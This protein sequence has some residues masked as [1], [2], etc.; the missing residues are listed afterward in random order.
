VE[1]G[2]VAE[3]GVRLGRLSIVLL[4]VLL[5]AC[6]ASKPSVTEDQASV[7]FDLLLTLPEKPIDFAGAVRPIIERRCVVCHGCYDAPCQLKLTSPEGIRRGASSIRV[8]DGARLRA[9]EPTRLRID[10][11]SVPDW[12]ARGFH[13]VLNETGAVSPLANLDE[14]VLYRMLR[15]KQLHPQ[16]RAGMLPDEVDVALDR[17]QVCTDRAGFDDFA[18]RN[19][20]WGMPYAMPNLEDAEYATLVQWIAQGSPMPGPEVPSPAA[21]PQVAAWEAFLNAPGNRQR[22]VSR[23]LYEHLVLA[24]IHLSGTPAR[25]FYRLVR[26]STPPGTSVEEIASV[27]PFDDPGTDLYYRLAREQGSIVAKD[28][29]LYEWS[30]ARMARYRELFLEPDYEVPELPGYGIEAASNPIRVFAA[31]PP[32]SRYRFLLDDA[33]FFIEGFMKGPVCRGQ[34]ALNVIEDRFW[35]FFRAP[36]PDAVML[37]PAFLDAAGAYLDLPAV[38]GD[39][40]LRIF[41][42]WRRFLELQQ[43]YL[44][45]KDVILERRFDDPSRVLD[46]RDALEVVWDGDGRNPNSA[47]TVFRHFDSASVRNGLV[48]DYPETAWII[49]YPLLERIH[50]L[51]VVGF[52]VFGNATHQL[53]TRLYMDFLRMEAENH[54][55][56]FMP[57]TERRAIHD[58]WY[59]AMHRRVTSA[60]EPYKEVTL[61]VD[62]VDGYRTGDPQREF[63]DLLLDRLGPLAGPSDAINRCDGTECPAERIDVAMRRMAGLRGEVLAVVPDVSFIRIRGA[64]DDGGDLA[65]TL[66][67]DKAY[68]NTTSLF[69]D[70]TARDRS[71][72]ALTILRGLEGAYPNFFFEIDATEIDDFVA[73]FAAIRD[74]EDYERFVGL[75]GV[76][77]TQAAFWAS[78]DWFQ[79]RAAENEPLRSGIFDLNRYRNR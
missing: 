50:Y 49:D 51:L 32:L 65:Y 71:E 78:A 18:R 11:R 67:L 57:A 6:T 46:I 29:T 74:R 3:A 20:L 63:Y 39:D 13:P 37:Q 17:E 15:L 61:N 33:R 25:E 40:S 76:R 28:H 55:L 14:S 12:R 30:P 75:Y 2:Q 72:D 4:L 31:I 62:T 53:T 23:Y 41:T 58:R 5:A 79:A 19:P 44:A 73:R 54:F 64:G 66:V 27:R 22:L 60:F 16:P 48:G 24:R 52:N 34:I 10:A 45:S 35:V 59:R 36:D 68:H 8:Y 7:D 42:T 21:Q 9:I 56:L 47:L 1:S 26:S 70:D 43:R 77:R 38:R 69:A